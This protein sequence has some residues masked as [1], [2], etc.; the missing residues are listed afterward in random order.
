MDRETAEVPRMHLETEAVN[1][2]VGLYVI[3]RLREEIRHHDDR[4]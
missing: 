3:A 2:G 4:P 1:R